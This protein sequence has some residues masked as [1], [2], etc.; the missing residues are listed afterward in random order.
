MT[1][2]LLLL[3]LFTLLTMVLFYEIYLTIKFY[4]RRYQRRKLLQ[5]QKV[6]SGYVL[7]L[8]LGTAFTAFVS[9]LV[10][11][12]RKINTRYNNP[13]LQTKNPLKNYI[14]KVK[15]KQFPVAYNDSAK[16]DSNCGS[17]L[18]YTPAGMK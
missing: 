15:R 13:F 3:N 8:I 18:P 6:S 17:F 4:Y 14:N 2:E 11:K 1:I 9:Y 12:Q 10:F 16:S 5:K 7:G